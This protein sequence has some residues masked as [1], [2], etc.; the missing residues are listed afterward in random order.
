MIGK[1]AN[2]LKEYSRGFKDKTS[3]LDRNLVHPPQRGTQRDMAMVKNKV[4]KDLLLSI[5]AN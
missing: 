2:R 5:V 3:C 4:G 1:F